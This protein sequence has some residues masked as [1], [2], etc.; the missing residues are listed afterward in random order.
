MPRRHD[1]DV[2]NMT[3]TQ[4]RREVMLLRG[5][6]R[7][8]RDRKGNARCWHN[9]LRLYEV[10]P[11]GKPAGRMD[12]PEGILLRKCK[13]YIRGQQCVKHGRKGKRSK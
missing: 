2:K 13:R 12:Q 6:I 5:R 1:R 7:W 8:H 4:L 3:A 9:D 10:L 11:E